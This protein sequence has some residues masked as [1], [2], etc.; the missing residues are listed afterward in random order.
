MQ[1]P[2]NIN[3]EENDGATPESSESRQN[4]P[5]RSPDTSDAGSSYPAPDES[6]R[7]VP[8]ESW[9]QGPSS[10]HPATGPWQ[11][12][13]DFQETSDMRRTRSLM[14]IGMI[15]AIVSLVIGGVLL[16]TVA[17][18]LGIIGYRTATRYAS[19]TSG[20]MQANW[21]IL[22]KSARIALIMSI[23]ALVLNAISMIY[24]YPIMLDF[25]QMNG[26]GDASIMGSSSSGSSVWG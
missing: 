7:V 16:S 20:Q 13:Q 3:S 25:L 4:V 19:T 22:R 23:C 18:I 24:L 6:K 11:P 26:F 5:H 10:N 21:V 9:K 15:L 12:H 8:A 1:G 17:L 2:N 14:S